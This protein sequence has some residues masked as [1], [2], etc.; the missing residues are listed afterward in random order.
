[1]KFHHSCSRAQVF[2]YDGSKSCTE[3]ELG[4]LGFISLCVVV[5]FVVP[6]PIAVGVLSIPRQ[7]QFQMQWHAYTLPCITMQHEA[8]MTHLVLHTQ[9]LYVYTEISP[10]G[11]CSHQ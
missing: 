3:W 4:I 8:I 10:V 11:R 6:A 2:L 1:M 5:L 9:L 7:V